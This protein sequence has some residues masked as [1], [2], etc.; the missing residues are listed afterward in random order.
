MGNRT[1]HRSS[2]VRLRSK[3]LQSIPSNH[4]PGASALHPGPR[5]FRLGEPGAEPVGGGRCGW[6]PAFRLAFEHAFHDE[7]HVCR[8]LREAAGEIRIP[9]IAEGD[10]NANVVAFLQERLLEVS[11]DAE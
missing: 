2:S 5:G 3:A 4:G 1:P 8:P 10:I 7:E 6:K 9:A 11:A